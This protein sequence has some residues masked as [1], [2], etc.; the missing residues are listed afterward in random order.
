M[1]QAAA[2]GIGA[3]AVFGGVITGIAATASTANAATANDFY[4][5]RVCE[6]SDN[7][8]DNTGN[9]Y[10][11][12]YQFDLSTWHSN[13][14]S[15]YPHEAS[16]AVQDQAAQLLYS[17]RGWQPWPVCSRRLGLVDSRASRDASRVALAPRVGMP[18]FTGQILTT[19]M[20][21]QRRAD[22]FQWQAQMRL[23]GWPI[24]VDGYFGAQSARI[25]RDFAIEKHVADGLLGQVG[26]K[27]WR[28]A[29]NMPVT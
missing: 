25:A 23:R 18:N 12:A 7:Y 11:G 22:V 4:R 2:T 21:S 3:T 26:H 17:R 5:L 24:A 28:A 9:G 16:P 14:F 27:L 19:A 8:R 6:S 1:T 20:S 10:Y 15:G 29:W 13:G